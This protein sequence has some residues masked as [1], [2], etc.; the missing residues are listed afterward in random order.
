M[1][2]SEPIPDFRPHLSRYTAC[3]RSNVFLVMAKFTNAQKI[4][5]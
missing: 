3:C 4:N 1:P 2:D 5:R